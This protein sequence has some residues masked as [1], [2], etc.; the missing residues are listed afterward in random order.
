MYSDHLFSSSV[1]QLMVDQLILGSPFLVM[2][3]VLQMTAATQASFWVFLRGATAYTSSLCQ[4]WIQATSRGN[5]SMR[6]TDPVAG[7]SGVLCP[8]QVTTGQRE[9]SVGKRVGTRIAR[10]SVRYQCKVSSRHVNLLIPGLVNEQK[11]LF[12]G[13]H[14]VYMPHCL[15]LAI[16]WCAFTLSPYL[17]WC[18]QR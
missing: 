12:S 15:C 17:W 13:F 6:R 8:E 2:V 4:H 16:H 3:K 10:A 18:E 5:L 1:W 14:C 7:S 9:S 11:V